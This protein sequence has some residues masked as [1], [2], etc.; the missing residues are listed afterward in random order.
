MAKKKN[1][2][3]CRHG[4]R[5][6][7][8][9]PLAFDGSELFI[10]GGSGSLTLSII[11]KNV[12][13][14]EN[15]VRVESAGLVIRCFDKGG[16]LIVSGGREIISKTLKFP[17]DGIAPGAAVGI[18]T[19]IDL[20][21][22]I[23][24]DFD[25]Y[26]GCIR[27]TSLVVTDFVRGDFFDEPEEGV[28]LTAGMTDE[29]IYDVC[30]KISEDALYY[31]DELSSLVW[32]CTCGEITDTSSCPKC[33]AE[34]AELFGFF[35]NLVRPARKSSGK[36][37]SKRRNHL[38]IALFS[39]VSFIIALVLALLLV[40]FLSD[41]RYGGRPGG[42]DFDDP[43][44]S[45]QKE[46]TLEEK[47]ERLEALIEAND[48]PA[49]LALARS[50]SSFADRIA[51]I[52]EQAVE[53]YTGKDDYD[54]AREFAK[55]TEDPDTTEKSILTAGYAYYVNNAIFDKALEYAKLLEDN[56]SIHTVYNLHIDHLVGE[57]KFS[58]A[59]EVAVS[60]NLETKK[61]SIITSAIEHLSSVRE[62]KEAFEFAKLSNK[63]N[64]PRDLARDAAYYYLGEND[65]ES[66]LDFSSYVN[67]DTLMTDIAAKLSDSQLRERLGEFFSYLSFERKQS[68]YANSV[69][70]D[71]QVAVINTAGKVFYGAG[72]TY[73]PPSGLSAVS[74]K[75]SAHHTV[76]LLSDGSVV[77]FGDNSFEQ[78]NVSLWKKVVAI[79]VGQYHTVALLEDGTVRAC[80]NRDFNQCSL[81]ELRDVI[82][83]SAGDY[84]TLALLADGTVRAVGMNSSSQCNTSSWENITMISA[85]ALH[86][87]GL[88]KDGKVVA[89]GSQS[90][91]RCDVS[92]WNNVVM[93]SAGSSHTLSLF[94]D[95]SVAMCGGVVGGGSCG[96]LAF[97]EKVVFI[98]AGNTSI[99]A[100]T[101]SG[102]LLF[103]GDGLP[104]ISHVT[105]EKVSTDFF[106]T[107]DD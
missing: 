13:T 100:I 3:I 65:V 73:I 30:D 29:E 20:S 12:S 79:E 82:M 88:T 63:E 78:C 21:P 39:V 86:S 16:N 1:K 54:R 91:G 42:P 6:A 25:I 99:V 104:N 67:E 59:I 31:P 27:T 96:S 94:A 36:D 95:G 5:S 89:V 48:F 102:K 74:V 22:D 66:A 35:T 68:I 32:R 38:L 17:E 37:N 43:S 7:L 75:T 62:Y 55:T 50:E 52:S 34:R 44:D 85:G 70:L 106:F 26:I 69:S 33:G 101:E 87:V 8:R 53:Y 107:N 46:E 72:Q 103:T 61:E 45:E 58:E 4:K 41:G 90:L 47:T 51:S 18:K 64:V 14:E 83:I 93:I 15:P 77:A 2:V 10:D 81:S 19:K 23:V 71:K 57:K 84:H 92:S 76:V 60:A 49:A 40:F 98:D 11:I 80:G 24:A 56:Q 97:G 105:R 9:S 28:L